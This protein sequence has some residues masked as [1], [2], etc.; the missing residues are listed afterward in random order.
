MDQQVEATIDELLERLEH[1]QAMEELKE[2]EKLKTERALLLHQI[3]LHYRARE[4]TTKLILETTE[5]LSLL[6][7]VA[8]TMKE[9][10][11]AAEREWLAYWGIEEPEQGEETSIEMRQLS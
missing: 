2:L 11:A 6:Q 7:M 5:M 4:K 3:E 8:E 10:Q 1:M 9:K